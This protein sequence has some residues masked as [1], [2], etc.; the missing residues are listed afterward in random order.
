MGVSLNEQHVIGPNRYQ[1][2]GWFPPLTQ[3]NCIKSMEVGKTKHPRP[4]EKGQTWLQ[5]QCC[6]CSTNVTTSSTGKDR[7]TN[8]KKNISPGRK[9]DYTDTLDCLKNNE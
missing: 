8:K 9:P 2:A 4:I 5:A 7:K 6:H 3:T 1:K